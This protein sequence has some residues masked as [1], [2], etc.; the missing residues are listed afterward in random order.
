[1]VWCGG[2][3]G[4]S[5]LPSTVQVGTV[6]AG[7]LDPASQSLVR[8]ERKKT[9]VDEILADA[10]IRSGQVRG[11]RGGMARHGGVHELIGWVSD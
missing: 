9:F 3:Q 8:K 6:V 11:W 1:V 5:S 4:L 2:L 7:R 10:S